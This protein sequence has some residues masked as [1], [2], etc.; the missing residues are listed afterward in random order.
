MCTTPRLKHQAVLAALVAD[1]AMPPAVLAMPVVV[2]KA[3]LSAPTPGAV[4][5]VPT[6]VAKKAKVLKESAPLT[7]DKS[8]VCLIGGANDGPRPPQSVVEIKNNNQLMMG[9]YDKEGVSGK[10]MATIIRVVGNKEGKGDREG[11]PL[12]TR[13]ECNKEGNGFSG[14]S[15]SNKGGGRATATRAMTTVMAKMWAMATAM[16]V[17]GNKEGNGNGDKR[18]GDGD[19]GGG[20]ATASRAK[21][22]A[23]ATATTWA[24][25]TTTRLVGNKEG[26]AEGGKDDGDSNEGC[27]QQGG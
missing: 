27:G 4:I 13:V 21:I 15:N 23:M 3:I 18:D 2:A 6:L 9:A 22:T 11:N 8:A 16:R 1:V 5:G 14:K 19:K 26:K 25:A 20:Q 12:A 17:A 10:A 7:L 24:M